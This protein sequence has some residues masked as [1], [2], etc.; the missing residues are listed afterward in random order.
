LEDLISVLNGNFEQWEDIYALSLV[1]IYGY[2][3]LKRVRLKWEQ[4]YNPL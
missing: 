3:P 2:I 1:R 4:L